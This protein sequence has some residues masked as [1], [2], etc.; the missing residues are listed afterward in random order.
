[1]KKSDG[2]YKKV[3]SYKTTKSYLNIS[4]KKGKTYYY[5]VR[6][7]KKVTVDGET[8]TIYAPWSKVKSFKR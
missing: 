1:M 3:S 4:A 8:K 6:A 2:S 7:Y 5:K